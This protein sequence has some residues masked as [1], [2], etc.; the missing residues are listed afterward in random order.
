MSPLRSGHHAATRRVAVYVLH[1]RST[2]CSSIRTRSRGSTKK[3][4]RLSD[5]FDEK[6]LKTCRAKNKKCYHCLNQELK[7]S[8][9]AEKVADQRRVRQLNLIAAV[10]RSCIRILALSTHFQVFD[11]LKQQIL[12]LKR[13]KVYSE[14]NEA[15]WST[16]CNAF[17]RFDIFYLN[18]QSLITKSRCSLVC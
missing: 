9:A 1:A 7:W 11:W 18:Q 17:N 12:L 14:Q 2:C 6:T 5:A 8:N 3:M 15:G 10:Q 4:R 13:L 16:S